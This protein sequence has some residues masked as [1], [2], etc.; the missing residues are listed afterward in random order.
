MNG[1]VR[2]RWGITLLLGFALLAGW[3]VIG[4]LS[5]ASAGSIEPRGPLAGQAGRQSRDE[6]QLE[7]TI[8]D[9][10]ELFPPEGVSGNRRPPGV[11][12]VVPLQRARVLV[13]SA[14]QDAE[15]TN[16]R[17]TRN[18]NPLTPSSG[19]DFEL[20]SW[21]QGDVLE[22]SAEWHWPSLIRLAMP[23]AEVGSATVA[24]EIVLQPRILTVTVRDDYSGW[25]LAG[26]L[27]GCSPPSPTDSQGQLVLAAP[28]LCLTVT[29]EH[30]GY[31]SQTLAYDGQAT[32][33]DVQLVPRI[34]QGVVLDAETLEPIAEA[35]IRRS[36]HTLVQTDQDGRFRLEDAA[37]TLPVRVRAKGY[38]PLDLSFDKGPVLLEPLPCPEPAVGGGLCTEIHL[39][40]F[41]AKA[42]YVPFGL[43]YV[44]ERM[45]AILDMISETELNSVVVDVK[46]DRGFLAYRSGLPLAT[47]LG[48]SIKGEMSLNEF[49]DLCQERGIYT[50]ARVVVFKDSPLAHARPELALRQADGSVWLDRE[51]LGWG[52][53]YRKEVWEYNVGIAVEVAQLGFDEVQ[54]DYVRFPS[55]GD[56]DEIVYD[57]EDS[58]EAKTA[59]IRA[60]VSRVREALGPHEVSLSVDVFGLTLVVDPECDMGIGQRVIDI[61]PY[62]DYLC[63]MVYPSTFAPGYLGLANPMLHPHEVVAESLRYGMGRT[64]TPLRPW[65]QGYSLGGVHYGLEELRL[66]RLAAE[67]AGAEGWAFWNA[68]GKYD[69]E[70]FR[71]PDA[72]GAGQSV[73]ADAPAR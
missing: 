36:G 62:V 2:H 42:V 16:V 35:A 26:A 56:L 9:E 20:S 27:V 4:Q 51:D 25:P 33:M 63:P 71:A 48:V 21:T 61:A 38:W 31:Y 68:S 39:E 40:P 12:H 44:S 17:V 15:L 11:P 50:I 18:G 14:T 29:V 6:R 8:T 24:F 72:G 53:P 67:Q 64:S 30:A 1:I 66:Q 3:G 43:W 22:A 34:L 52:N 45:M 70:L 57:E 46:G 5:S 60:F 37:A 19:G 47:E 13:R 41:R 59:A 7:D 73:R 54:L 58:P 55:G 69:A 10:R 23:A 32:E 49:M 28:A 65:L